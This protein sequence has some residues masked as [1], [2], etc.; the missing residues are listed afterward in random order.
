MRKMTGLISGGVRQERWEAMQLAMKGCNEGSR[1]WT[2]SRTLEA[3]RSHLPSPLAG[4]SHCPE[5]RTRL[6]PL[7]SRSFGRHAA[8]R[9]GL[10]PLQSNHVS[11]DPGVI[12]QDR[13]L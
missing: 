3:P 4:P 1:T 13:A 10:P 12:W 8:N 11:A 7:P 9:E 2:D 5:P 6:P